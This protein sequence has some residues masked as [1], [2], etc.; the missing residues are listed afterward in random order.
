RGVTAS[1]AQ[2]DWAEAI[3]NLTRFLQLVGFVAL[4]LGGIGVASAVTVYV[5]QKAETVATLRCLGASAGRVLGI[6]VLQA[7]GMGLV[8]AVAGAALGV[9]VQTLLPR[10]LGP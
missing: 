3:G 8:G 10:V 9:A 6:Y 7:L 1:G 4:L 5:R 2:E